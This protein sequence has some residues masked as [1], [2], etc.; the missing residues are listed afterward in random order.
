[1]TPGGDTTS[2]FVR[3]VFAGR[4]P[5]AEHVDSLR[6]M[7]PPYDYPGARYLSACTAES[8][9]VLITS[10]YRPELYYAAGRGFAAGRLYYLNSLA[11]SPEFKAFSLE[12]LRAERVPVA[13]VEPG[14]GEFADQFRTLHQYVQQHYRAA[15]RI[16]FSGV[17]FEVLVDARIAPTGTWT[18]GLPCY[19]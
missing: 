12:R 4:N 19:H 7:T 13:L 10:G 3:T 6:A 1:G 8:D 18:N 5:L 14:D 2:T 11:P 9:R 16:E 15:G 17:D